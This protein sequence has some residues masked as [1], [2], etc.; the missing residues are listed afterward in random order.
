MTA[1]AAPLTRFIEMTMPRPKPDG[2]C[3]PLEVGEPSA[4]ASVVLV[5]GAPMLP[6]FVAI[7]DTPPPAVTFVSTREAVAPEG[8]WSPRAMEISGSPSRASTVLNRT[9]SALPADRVEGQRDGKAGRAA[10]RRHDL[11]GEGGRD[12][13]RVVGL[14]VDVPAGRRDAA[15][16]EQGGGGADVRRLS[17]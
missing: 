1:S 15:V 13:R 9:F 6:A 2:A 5:T 3:E 16:A 17:R 4:I 14:D 11:V 12:G 8:I 10:G 7:T